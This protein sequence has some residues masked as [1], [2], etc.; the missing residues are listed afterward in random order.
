MRRRPP[1]NYNGILVNGAA[2]RPRAERGYTDKAGQF[3]LA[4]RDKPGVV[5]L[6]QVGGTGRKRHDD[7]LSLACFPLAAL[8]A[9]RAKRG[10]GP[11]LSRWAIAENAEHSPRPFMVC[12]CRPGQADAQLFSRP[13]T[14]CQLPI[15]RPKHLQQAR[16]GAERDRRRPGAEPSSRRSALLNPAARVRS[17]ANYHSW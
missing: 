15:A 1:L 8:P 11:V 17:Y 3:F 12:P 10:A 16:D 7:R 4:A 2:S 5:P 9:L 14:V 6:Q 13:A